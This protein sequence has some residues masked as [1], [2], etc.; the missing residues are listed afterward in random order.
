[1]KYDYENMI[2]EKSLN[3][4]QITAFLNYVNRICNKIDARILVSKFNKEISI[5]DG[6]Y[7]Q[8]EHFENAYKFM[9]KNHFNKTG[10]VSKY[11]PFNKYKY[12]EI[13]DHLESIKIL[14]IYNAYTPFKDF[15]TPV[16]RAIATNG[17]YFEY[18]VF[19]NEIQIKNNDNE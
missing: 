16:Y 14:E 10:R 13:I 9:L 2:Y 8:R 6:L 4:K 19:N 18:G 3:K 5:N 1:M 12:L 15:Y 7:L 17:F 11:T